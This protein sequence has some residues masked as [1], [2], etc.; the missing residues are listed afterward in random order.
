MT[1]IPWSLI[2]II[3]VLAVVAL[4]VSMCMSARKAERTAKA[5]ANIAV[6]T[7]QALDHVAEQTPAIRREQ[8]EKQ[9]EVD[10]IPGADQRLPDG[11]GA[12]LERVRR[13]ERK[14]DDPR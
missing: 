3:A 10:E 12:S 5:N 6:A 4:S 9:R 13:G 8:E 2:L 11:Y 1:R 7:G 14:S